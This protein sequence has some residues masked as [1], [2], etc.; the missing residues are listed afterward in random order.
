MRR[1]ER[2]LEEV[3][4]FATL[5]TGPLGDILRAAGVIVERRMRQRKLAWSE[6]EDQEVV[7]LSI[8]ALMQTVLQ[9]THPAEREVMEATLAAMASCVYMRMEAN[10][11]GGSSIDGRLRP[12]LPENRVIVGGVWVSKLGVMKRVPTVEDLEALSVDIS[13]GL[14]TALRSAR[15]NM[16]REV[17]QS[18]L[19]VSDLDDQQLLDLFADEFIKAAAAAYSG[20]HRETVQKVLRAMLSSMVVDI[21]AEGGGEKSIH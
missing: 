11:G 8:A 17:R 4:D 2:T 5:M 13:E 14:K 19:T 12:R 21:A 1:V 15:A 7:D 18:G 10:F 6:L 3:R 16:E 9:S 20:L